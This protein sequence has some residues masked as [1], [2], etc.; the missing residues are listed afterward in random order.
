MEK[1]QQKKTLTDLEKRL[2]EID[3]AFDAICSRSTST[4][5]EK[6]AKGTL[7]SIITD[8]GTL[9]ESIKPK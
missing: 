8:L 2:S 6:E 1:I 9:L 7:K 4:P 3:E 5:G